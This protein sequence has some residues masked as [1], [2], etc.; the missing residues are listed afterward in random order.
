MY[1][2]IT[3][4]ICLLIVGACSVGFIFFKVENRTE[5]LFIPQDSKAIRDL[6]E[7]NKYFT[8]KVREET[9]LLEASSGANVLT[10]T[11]FK[12]ALKIHKEIVN[13]DSYVDLCATTSGVKS[14]SSR[15][16]LF[17]NPLEVFNFEEKNLVNLTQ[18]ITN[19]Y[20]DRGWRMRN[21]RPM[22]YNF[23]R[24]FG[25]A[26]KNVRGEVLDARAIQMTYYIRDPED[27]DEFSDVNKWEKKFI[28]KVSSLAAG[29]SCGKLHYS[30]ERS[31]DDAISESTGSDIVLVSITFTLMISFACTMLGKFKNPLTGHSLLANAGVFAVALGILSGFGLSML[32]GVPFI[33]LVGVLPFLVIGIGIDDMF[34]IVDELDR[35]KPQHVVDTVKVVMSKSG[36]TVTMTT[37]TDLVAFAVSTSTSFPAIKYFCIYAA[38]SLTCAYLMIITYFVAIMTFDI[39]RIKSG[40]RDCLPVCRAPLPKEGEAAWDEPRP[41]VSNKVMKAWAKFLMLPGTKVAVIIVSLGLLGAGI[42][43]ATK[44]DERF[45]RR[46]LAKDDSYLIQFL[47]AQ[48]KYFEL[49]MVVSVVM[50]GK[51]KYEDNST[52][53][54]IKKL[55]GIVTANKHY[56]NR[57]FSWLDAFVKFTKNNKMNTNSQEHFMSAIKVFLNTPDYSLFHE[58]IKLSE[59]QRY[60]EAS[61][62][63]GYMKASSSSTFHRDA[64]LTLRKDISSKSELPAFPIT[65][66]FIY[67]EQYVIVLSETIKNLSIA[68]GAILV[69]TSPF[70]VDL[71]VIML[72]T[73]GFVALIFELFGLMYIWGV[74]LNTVSMIN[75]VMAIGFAVDYSAHIAHAFVTSEERTANERVIDALSTLGASVLMGG[76]MEDESL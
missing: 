42:Y 61:R 45:D 69:L 38:L 49:S 1:P 2:W 63:I 46:L 58:D 52:Q 40:R 55:C 37:L 12:E 31:L 65:K 33:S 18:L 76:K 43:G 13:L 29:I 4:C 23:A 47:D 67:I 36:A 68:A 44:I 70:L 9:V 30:A 73:L 57:T 71:T 72:V 34:I 20:N 66:P 22:R 48:E 64:M 6:D 32:A 14:N 54:G 17:V 26:T 51:A 7:A 10:P 62:I 28:D 25:G 3:V 53:D 15:S 27:D 50:T 60:I 16:C 5:K 35:R 56:H 39:K 19:T 59:D 41:Q 21:G 24:L 8:L 74:S 75:L 11:C